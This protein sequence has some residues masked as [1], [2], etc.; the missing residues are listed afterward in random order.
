MITGFLQIQ[1]AIEKFEETKGLVR[2]GKIYR[3]KYELRHKTA[4]DD[5]NFQCTDDEDE[6]HDSDD[7]ELR[8][9]QEHDNDDD[10]LRRE[11]EQDNDHEDKQLR[12]RKENQGDETVQ[13]DDNA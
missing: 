13:N 7:E 5:E 8:S 3:P 11:E 2:L 10:D 4:E 6:E 1:E 9:E 12:R